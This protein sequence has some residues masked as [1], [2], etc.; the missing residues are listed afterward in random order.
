M[1]C[2]RW[3]VKECMM[4]DLSGGVRV[5]LVGVASLLPVKHLK[6]DCEDGSETWNISKATDTY[7]YI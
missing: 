7:M 2:G 3:V 4:W 5:E 1:C 6:I